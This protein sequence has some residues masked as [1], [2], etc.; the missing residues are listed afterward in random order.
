MDI[1]HQETNHVFALVFY[2]FQMKAMPLCF[3]ALLWPCG[4]QWRL[5]CKRFA[6]FSALDWLSLEIGSFAKP[7]MFPILKCR[8]VWLTRKTCWKTCNILSL[9]H[10]VFPGCSPRKVMATGHSGRRSLSGWSFLGTPFANKTWEAERSTSNGGFMEIIYEKWCNRKYPHPTSRIWNSRVLAAERPRST[11]VWTCSFA[12]GLKGKRASPIG[13]HD[14]RCLL[15][16]SLVSL[17]MFPT[18]IGLMDD[19]RMVNG[20]CKDES[21]MINV[22]LV[23]YGKPHAIPHAINL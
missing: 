22:I 5:F 6:L 16:N 1:D 17:P 12:G 11:C 10:Q 19:Y 8:F 4:R 15:D 7:V 3:D 13:L 9:D 23:R 18:F 20:W 2:I 14:E 21:W